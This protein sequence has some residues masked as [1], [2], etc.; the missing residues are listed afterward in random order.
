[1]EAVTCIRLAYGFDNTL[2]QQCVKWIN[3]GE[4]SR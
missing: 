2:L 3:E 1:M 4:T